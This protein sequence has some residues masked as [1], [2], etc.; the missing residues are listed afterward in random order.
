MET[1][2][3]PMLPATET[4]CLAHGQPTG[5]K[6]LSFWCDRRDECARHVSIRTD[7]FDGTRV[8]NPRLCV[9]GADLFVPLN[10]EVV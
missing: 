9:D 3:T 4:R 8:V 1:N 2:S 6:G 10:K 5:G 7:P